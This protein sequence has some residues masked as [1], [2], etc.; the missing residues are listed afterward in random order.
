MRVP[1]VKTDEGYGPDLPDGFRGTATLAEDGDY[2]LTPADAT[3]ALRAELDAI[4]Q[5]AAEIE[6]KLDIIPDWQPGIDVKA[7]EVYQHDGANW[8]V[9]QDHT[10]QANWTPGSDGLDALYQPA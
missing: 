10:T 2:L 9:V 5:R 4:K 6:A 8:R 7:D 1:K 3:E